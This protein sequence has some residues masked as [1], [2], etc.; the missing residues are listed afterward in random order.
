MRVGFGALMAV[1]L[2]FQLNF[3]YS[4]AKADGLF[5]VKPKIIFGQHKAEFKSPS[6][7]LKSVIIPNLSYQQLHFLPPTTYTISGIQSKKSELFGALAV[8]IDFYKNFNLPLRLEL[9]ISSRVDDK[10][11]GERVKIIPDPDHEVVI[12]SDSLSYSLHTAYLN[13]YFDLHNNS[14]FLPYIGGGIG[15][16]YKKA[17]ATVYANTHLPV[18]FTNISGM[19]QY[20]TSVSAGFVSDGGF[21]NRSTDFAWHFDV[22]I[23]YFITD[24]AS[25]DLSYRYADIGKPL[26]LSGVPKYNYWRHNNHYEKNGVDIADYPDVDYL[27][28]G[29]EEIKF[30]TVQQLTLGLKYSFF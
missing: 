19:S 22:G 1:I 27:L 26:K 28:Y 8:G 24:S 11:K 13:L 7:E 21:E 5:Y 18:Y 12:G 9:E 6:L 23:S 14:R 20:V 16:A 2:A 29:P 15:L 10:V 3:C 4:E 17:K 25:I 30:K